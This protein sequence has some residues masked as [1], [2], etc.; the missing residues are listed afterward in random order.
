MTFFHCLFLYT[1]L[2]ESGAPSLNWLAGQDN[3]EMCLPVPPCVPHALSAGLTS[4]NCNV[5]AG[6]PNPDAHACRA[7]LNP[8]PPP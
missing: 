6:D 7:R 8:G 4:G 5:G 3:P 1:S 2:I